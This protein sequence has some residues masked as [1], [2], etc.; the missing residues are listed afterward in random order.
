MS[1]QQT[2]V[3]IVDDEPDI[4]DALRCYLEVAGDYRISTES[5]P[6]RA[7]ELLG[8]ERV[9]VVLS[10]INMPGM[11]GIELLRRIKTEQPLLQVVM[12]TAFSTVDKVMECVQA[13]A[14]DYILKPLTDM[15]A[16][17]QIIDEAARRVQRW[18]RTFLATMRSGRGAD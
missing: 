11:S 6:L 15:E 10:D 7:L 1:P 14:A 3:L 16:A 12:M 8:R 9:D 13:G 5:D 2:H 17:A 4:L 18:R